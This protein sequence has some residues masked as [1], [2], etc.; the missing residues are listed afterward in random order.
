MMTS[1]SG[2][3]TGT[4]VIIVVLCLAYM[5][6]IWAVARG[7]H[8]RALARQAPPPRPEPDLKRLNGAL[9]SFEIHPERLTEHGWPPEA[10]ERLVN[11]WGPGAN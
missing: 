2:L 11:G 4:S 8:N 6:I 1:T 10:D 3:N 5:Y 9:I 7:R